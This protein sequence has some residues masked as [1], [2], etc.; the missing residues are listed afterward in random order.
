MT[1]NDALFDRILMHGAETLST[2][3]LLA[4]L[5]DGESSLAQANILVSTY[6]DLHNLA[7][8]PLLDL[9][10]MLSRTHSGRIAATFELCKRL[11]REQ[12][13]ERPIIESAADAAALLSDMAYLPQEHVRVMLLDI[14]R[15]VIAMPTIY[16]GT[17][18]ASVLRASEI[19]RAAILRGSA[20]MILAHNHPSGDPTPS[21]ED[22]EMT[23]SLAAAGRLLDI[24]LLDHL[25]IGRG[26]WVSIKEMGFT[27]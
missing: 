13:L 18:T 14:N 23:R 16:I 5:L 19:Y 2:I 12:T 9:E 11:A 4:V 24:A 17:L 7:Q 6:P 3:E 8:T 20:L 22:V 27:F 21:P 15:R 10:H 26:R 1:T 25:I